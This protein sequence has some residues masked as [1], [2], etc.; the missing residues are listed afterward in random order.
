M[1]NREQVMKLLC[2]DLNMSYDKGKF[3]VVRNDDKSSIRNDI[4]TIAKDMR[5]VIGKFS[6]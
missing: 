5:K 1:S 3:F 6:H 4:R 2:R